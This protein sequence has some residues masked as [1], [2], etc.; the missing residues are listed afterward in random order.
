MHGPDYDYPVGDYIQ[1]KGVRYTKNWGEYTLNVSDAYW[2]DSDGDWNDFAPKGAPFTFKDV[3]SRSEQ[4]NDIMLWSEFL[5]KKKK[6]TKPAVAHT[7]SK[8]S[9]SSNSSSSSSSITGG[10]HKKK[11]NRKR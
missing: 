8:S 6:P 2:L 11:R 5:R 9:S 10:Q 7:S 1:T 3:Q 4:D